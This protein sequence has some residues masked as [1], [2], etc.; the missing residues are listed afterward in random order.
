[1]DTFSHFMSL[2]EPGTPHDV[3]DGAWRASG[4]R[5]ATAI[6]ILAEIKAKSAR[7][8]A[9]AKPAPLRQTSVQPKLSFASAGPAAVRSSAG[10]GSCPPRPV[11][12][13]APPAE[14]A[15]VKRATLAAQTRPRPP[16]TSAIDLVSSSD[17]DGDVARAAPLAP[18]P[19]PPASRLDTCGIEPVQTGVPS[20]QGAWPRTLPLLPLLGVS[21]VRGPF[22][23]VMATTP[24]ACWHEVSSSDAASSGM[25]GGAQSKRGHRGRPGKAGSEGSSSVAGASSAD[26]DASVFSSTN[27]RFGLRSSVGAIGRLPPDLS[28]WLAPLIDHGLAEAVVYLPFRP[29]VLAV[30]GSIDLDVVVTLHGSAARLLR[31]GR[32]RAAPTASST[33][34]VVSPLDKALSL[35]LFEVSFFCS[36]GRSPVQPR[37]AAP[38][39]AAS[40][41]APAAGGPVAAQAPSTPGDPSAAALEGEAAAADNAE[42]RLSAA[43]AQALAAALE[44]APPLPLA[45]QPALLPSLRLRHYQRQALAWM[46]GRETARAPEGEDG[47]AVA[48]A[49]SKGMLTLSGVVATESSCLPPSPPP[50]RDVADAAVAEA[51][52][53]ADEHVRMVMAAAAGGSE[54]ATFGNAASMWEK[55]TFGDGVTDLWLNEYTRTASLLP[56]PRAPPCLSGILCDGERCLPAGVT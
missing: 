54:R 26:D 47:A 40:A 35:A 43:D 7:S 33:S 9:A 37:A 11:L 51:T 16:Q 21:L 12:A 15:G 3:L 5:V 20:A 34:A 18:P 6:A 42:E 39:A 25:P 13:I 14:P 56:P 19:P 24:L 23:E 49:S 32:Q 50:Q 1:M 27:V 29:A 52:A 2:A 17:D 28:R 46:I 8:K 4:R 31:G 10:T 36:H 38:I 53:A 22:P 30:A 41:P 45:P 55:T 48:L 44:L